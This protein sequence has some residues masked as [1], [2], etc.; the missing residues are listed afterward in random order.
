MDNV[1]LLVNINGEY[2]ECVREGDLLYIMKDELQGLYLE[3]LTNE[4]FCLVE[5]K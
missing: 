1:L 4:V 5:G 3:D 2:Y